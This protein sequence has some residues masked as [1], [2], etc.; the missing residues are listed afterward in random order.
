MPN[1]YPIFPHVPGPRGR[2]RVWCESRVGACSQPPTRHPLR[3]Y[4]ARRRQERGAFLHRLGRSRY[5]LAKRRLTAKSLPWIEALGA[6][7]EPVGLVFLNGGE[8]DFFA[9]LAHFRGE[10]RRTQDLRQA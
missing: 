8:G 1:P 6:H 9:E 3:G 5:P 10:P 7:H 4:P 2:V